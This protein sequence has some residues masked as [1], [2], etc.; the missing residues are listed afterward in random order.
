MTRWLTEWLPRLVA[1]APA[2]INQKLL[3]AFLSIVVLL[4]MVGAVG[5]QVLSG[6]NRRAEEAVT[7]QRKIA[8]YRQLQHDTTAQLYS[9]TSAL[10]VPDAPTLEATVRQLNQFGYD[11]DRLQFVAKDEVELLAEVRKEYDQ[12]IQVVAKVVELIREGKVGEGR[13]LQAAQ[14]GPLADRMERLTN[15]LVNRAEA[16]MVASIEA[17]QA[18]HLTS[19]WIIICVGVGS[20]AL[21]L[22]LGY[23]I[24]WSVIRPV[25]QMEARFDEMASGDFSGRIEVPNR[26]EL[27]NL[28]GNLN[29]MNDELGRLYRQL[30][31][32][33]LAKSRFL[34]AASHDL[35]QPLH[36]LNLFVAQL[37]TET[38]QAERNRVTAQIDAAV[39]AMNDLFSA[40]LDISKLDAGALAPDV[41]DFPLASVLQRIERTFAPAALEK[42]LRLRMMLSDAWVS[43]DLILLERILMNLVSNAIRYTARGGVIVGCRRRGRQ[44]RIE[45]WDSG[46]GIPED[47][48]ENIFGEF[49]QVAA[50][51]RPNREGLGLG[52]AI[53]DRLCRLLDHRLELASTLGRGSRFAVSL[54]MVAAPQEPVEH[55]ITSVAMADPVS[56]KLIVVIDDDALV[57]DAM[58]GLLRR[59]GCLVVTAESESAAQASLAGDDRRP[60]L[61]ISDYGLADGHTGIEAIQ[62]LRS[63]FRAP[64]PA[65]L[66]TGDIA[67]ERLRQASAN[68]FH[69][70]HKPVGPMALRAMLNQIL[71]AGGKAA[72]SLQATAPYGSA[73]NPQRA[74]NP[75]L[76]HPLR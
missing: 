13:A 2:T 62:R 18:A 7:L 9:V 38:D 51:G 72:D 69:L 33:N 17:S 47:Q 54:P 22:V 21:A 14:A 58:R 6:V 4:I 28:A 64:I 48:R 37:R 43:S 3:A 15:Q 60:D 49:Y 40:L 8:A 12:F 59:W 10:L 73:T 25:K 36:A 67:P 52:L 35:R 30:E 75:S 26:D 70:L 24:S 50:P 61:I 53:V 71:R 5:L 23:A 46:I 29:R 32:A 1:R 42:G 19:Q 45:V 68:G 63:A 41:T 66:V 27:G 34:A 44:V 57:L 16:D 55:A 11:F 65:F 31:A 39:T 76:A 56:G 20:I 74:A